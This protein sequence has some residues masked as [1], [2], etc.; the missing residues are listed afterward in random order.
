MYY[1]WSLNI[2]L[3]QYGND[4]SNKENLQQYKHALTTIHKTVKRQTLV[5]HIKLSVNRSFHTYSNKHIKYQRL[6]KQDSI[7]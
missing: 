1:G 4:C 3:Q 5:K 7:W 2:C 6:A